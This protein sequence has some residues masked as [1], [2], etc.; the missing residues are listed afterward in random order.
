MKIY[1]IIPSLQASKIQQEFNQI[2]DW[3]A[4]F[5]PNKFPIILFRIN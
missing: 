2:V 5:A 4:Y 1:I 3:G